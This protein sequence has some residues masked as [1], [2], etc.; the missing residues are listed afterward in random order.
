MGPTRSLTNAGF[1]RWARL[2]DGH[3][4][5]S[6]WQIDVK[7]EDNVFSYLVHRC[8]IGNQSSY[9]SSVFSDENRFSES[10]KKR[11]IIDLR[12]STVVN[13]ENF[14]DL[15]DFLYDTRREKEL[16]LDQDKALCMLYFA[17]YFGIKTALDQ[18]LTFLQT[19]L[20]KSTLSGHWLSQLYSLAEPL[21]LKNLQDTIAIKCHDR[22]TLFLD[23][24]SCLCA[25]DVLHRKFLRRMCWHRKT[26]WLSRKHPWSTH[27]ASIISN[28]LCI[29]D[30]NLFPLLTEKNVMPDIETVESALILLKHEKF[31][32]LDEKEMNELT[33]LQQRCTDRIYDKRKKVWRSENSISPKEIV[34]RLRYLK[35]ALMEILMVQSME[36]NSDRSEQGA[37]Q[38]RFEQQ[39]Q[40]YR[41]RRRAARADKKVPPAA[42]L[43]SESNSDESSY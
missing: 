20:E 25:G 37:A 17:D 19:Q 4:E 12:E 5:Y 2:P 39:T 43:Y 34:E 28:N 21:S 15:L 23:F 42:Y 29:V 36:C 13:K 30:I 7:L 10:Q 40:L 16:K 32:G 27:L 1:P 3:T 41:V 18:T 26:G 35:P 9:F 14:E 8:F 31:L 33:C 11:S 38:N 24:W 22:P 6:D